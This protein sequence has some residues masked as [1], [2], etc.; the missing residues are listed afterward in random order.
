MD[1]SRNKDA[2]LEHFRR[3][4]ILFGYHI[5][6]LD[7]FYFDR[8]KW[9]VTGNNGI[10]EVALIYTGLEIPTVLAFGYGN[11][12]NGFL[13]SLISELPEQ[14]YCHYRKSSGGV[15]RRIYSEKSLGTHL[16]MK[17]VSEDY[18][19]HLRDDLEIQRLDINHRSGL[20]EL[21]EESY[22]DN[23]FDDRML[24]TGKYL[25]CFMDGKLACVGGVHVHSNEYEISILGN[26]T[27]HPDYRGRGLATA[28]T[29]SLL[30][31][32]RTGSNT[33]A[34]NVK[35]DNYAAIKCYQKLGFDV[36]CEYEESFF[37]R[38]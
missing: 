18:I 13:E 29:A 10:E 11:K 22:P 24:E 34:L 14:F 4:P 3:D 27:T 31:D 6:D 1:Y 38:K 5:G 30:K 19:S 15:F 12:F 8:C 2:L 37:T 26:I 25:G 9:A 28:L 33:I 32:L 20:L 16:K 36:Y 35:K 23:Y 21:Y 17:L 7:D